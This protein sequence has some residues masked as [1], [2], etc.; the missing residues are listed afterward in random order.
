MK[1]TLLTVR[2]AKIGEQSFLI[3]LPSGS[4]GCP[5]GCSLLLLLLFTFGSSSFSGYWSQSAFE[6]TAQVK[7]T[8]TKASLTL[9][10]HTHTYTHK[11]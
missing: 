11:R 3:V 2:P 6:N 10:S 8:Q 5:R 7:Q 9:S 1:V 4:L